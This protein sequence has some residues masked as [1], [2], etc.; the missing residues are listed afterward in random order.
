MLT[1]ASRIGA[2]VWR[3]SDIACGALASR[4]VRARRSRRNTI[5]ESEMT[6]EVPRLRFMTHH[7]FHTFPEKTENECCDV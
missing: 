6:D 1:A 4:L 5:S 2:A 7:I 3:T